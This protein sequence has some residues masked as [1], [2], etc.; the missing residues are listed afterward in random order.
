MTPGNPDVIWASCYGNTVTRF[1]ARTGRARSVSPWIHTLDSPPNALKYRCHWTPPL[2]IDPF[3]PE[4]VYY[5]CQVIFK[6]SNRG[7][8]WTV[9][10]PDLSTRDT[11]RIVS[12]GGIIGD[13]LGQF[14]G[15][16]VFAIA[17]S[18]ARRG[19]IWAGTNDGKIWLTRDGGAAWT[20]LTRN[21]AG[22]P[23]WGTVR[24][25]EPSRHDPAVAYVAVDYHMMD[26]RRPF[27][28]KT[29]DYGKT[30]TNVT[31]DLPTGHP[32]D[33]VMAVAE[34]PHRRGML[35]AGT[36]RAFYW[37][38]DDGKHWT[39][40]KDGLPAAP[41]TWIVTPKDW[42]DVVVSTY[43]RGVFVLRDITTL[44]QSDRVVAD[45]EAHLYA[46]RAAFRLAR[47]GSVDVNYTLRA[48]P[49]DSVR[50]EILDAA[51]KVVRTLRQRGRA[52]ANRVAW[53]LRHDGPRQ[54][55]LR[56]LPPD[57]PHVWEEA[58]F[59]GRTTRPINHW[60]IQGPQ[61]Q[62]P[63]VVPGTYAVRLTV[64]GKSY[65]QPLPVLKD[66]SIAATPAELAA[67]SR[68]QL[69]V[70]DAMN[71]T[72]DMANR[73]EAMRK[74]VEDNLKTAA[75]NAGLERQL[76]EIDRK[77]LDVELRLLS[78]TDLHSDDKWYVEPYKLYMSLIWLGG[79]IGSGA[80]DVAGGADNRPTDA[81]LAWLASLERELVEARAAYRR[82]LEVDVPAFN[83]A[84]AGA[85]GAISV[86]Q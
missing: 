48:A 37:S 70:R 80:G 6:T 65:T 52:G 60:G 82:L 5:G 25:I 77:M 75:G 45:A 46:P 16:V 72:V 85:V 63:L 59:R 83:R 62:G 19:L 15:E 69:R 22:M 8:T 67:S 3:D 49:G 68:A 39:R 47:G 36:G 71:E 34:S 10:S 58:R 73:L 32:L 29:A 43:G 24:K 57:N 11:S 31:G 50:V 56:T 35:F 55:E 23:A 27:V 74:Q 79:E 42:H 1:D 13:N 12:S 53:D 51:G 28:F 86:L 54:V 84:T 26:D 21:V 9:L 40:L 76:R 64:N 66:P 61:R 18:E 41:V 2:A 4:T 14:Y 20:D 38:L 81:S 44:E 7:Q 33:Y 30:W 78:R 17:P